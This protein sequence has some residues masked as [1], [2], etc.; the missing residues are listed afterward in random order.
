MIEP[1]ELDLA[2]LRHEMRQ[3]YA[4]IGYAGSLQVFY[5]MLK[6]AEV[7]AN[8]ILEERAKERGPI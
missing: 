5:E 6:G 7:F 1:S 2:Q 3:L 4:H 8:V